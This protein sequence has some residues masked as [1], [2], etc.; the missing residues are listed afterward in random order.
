MANKTA[1]LAR[2]NLVFVAPAEHQPGL[3]GSLA[4]EPLHQGRKEGNDERQIRD[5]N[6]P[7]FVGNVTWVW[8]SSCHARTL[9]FP[10]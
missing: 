4:P 5:D 9:P 7:L 10:S 2:P 1:I 8:F 6:R 3:I